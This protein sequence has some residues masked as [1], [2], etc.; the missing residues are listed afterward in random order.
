MEE[1]TSSF[2]WVKSLHNSKILIQ[3]YPLKTVQ[4]AQMKKYLE[5]Y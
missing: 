1:I 5:P 2:D 4:S 3:I